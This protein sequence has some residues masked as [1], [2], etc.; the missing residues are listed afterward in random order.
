MLRKQIKSTLRCGNQ[1]IELN[2]PLV[3]GILNTTPDSFY[4]AGRSDGS[5]ERA[6]EM[7]GEM[8]RNGAS[9]LD[10]GGMSSRPGAKE[11]SVEEELKRVLPVV[12]AVSSAFPSVILSVDTFRGTVAESVIKAGATMINDISGGEWDP[13]LLKVVASHQVAYVLMHMRGR[14]DNMHYNTEYQDLIGDILKYF[15]NR[16]NMLCKAGISEIV[17]DPGFGFAKTPEQNFRLIDRLADFRVLSH[18]VMVGISRK[19]TLSRT[20]GRPT[21]ETL[22]ATSAL[23]MAALENGASILRAHDVRPAMDV[24]AVFNQIE[25]VRT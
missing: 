2:Q 17:L 5:V 23:H 19:S 22:D 7:A 18:P 15:V 16:L 21:E 9:I 25:S 4:P 10:V 24:I 14:P 13:E 20:I 3:M 12:E 8:V 1:V 6:L 11:V